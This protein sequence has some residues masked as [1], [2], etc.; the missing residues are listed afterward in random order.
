MKQAAIDI[1]I[2]SFLQ[3]VCAPATRKCMG[4]FQENTPFTLHTIIDSK[5]E[6][7]ISF[8]NSDILSYAEKLSALAPEFV[9]VSYELLMHSYDLYEN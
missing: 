2:L 1:Y 8:I 5:T 6:I 7:D 3:A 4:H 9:R